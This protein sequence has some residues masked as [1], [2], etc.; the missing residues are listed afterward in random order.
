MYN[1]SIHNIN[2]NIDLAACDNTTVVLLD[3]FLL[4]YIYYMIPQ[5]IQTIKT[6]LSLHF[7]ITNQEVYAKF[8]E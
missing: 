2:L 4:R 5:N 7:I 3:T 8:C 6:T 1:Q